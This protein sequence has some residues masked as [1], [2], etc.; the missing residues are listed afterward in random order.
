MSILILTIILIAIIIIYLK[1]SVGSIERFYD[2]TPYSY[3]WN[4]SKCNS[5]PCVMKEGYKCYLWCLNWKEPGAQQACRKNC[6][7]DT[8]NQMNVLKWNNY[9][10]NYLQPRFN[11][12]A[13]WRNGADYETTIRQFDK[14]FSTAKL[15]QRQ[16]WATLSHNL[17]KIYSTEVKSS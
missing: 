4:I 1:K 10:W 13:A 11:A 15:K 7:D 2:I 5:T 9:T 16:D 3:R 17:G 6:L 14:R 12:V 8:D